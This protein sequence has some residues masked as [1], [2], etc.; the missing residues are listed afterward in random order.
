LKA[1]VDIAALAGFV[2]GGGLAGVTA[3]AAVIDP[4][5]AVLYAAGMG[6]VISVAGFVR[7]WAN[8]TATNTVQVF[9]RN[10]GST[11]DIKTTSTPS[12]EPAA[13]PV[14]AKGSP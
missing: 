9:D 11:V 5:H 6:A 13:A 8:P 2:A 4:K 1:P 10:T 7:T 3:L 12:P 14:Y